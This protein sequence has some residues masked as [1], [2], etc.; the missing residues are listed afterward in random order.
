M[1]DLVIAFL[2]GTLIVA[3]GAF[4]YETKQSEDFAK[5]LKLLKAG[6]LATAYTRAMAAYRD[7][8]PRIA[9]WELT[10]LIALE[11]ED[12]KLGLE[13]NGA[14]AGLMLTHARLARLYH[15]QGR[16]VEAQTNADEAISFMRKLPG[17]DTAVTNLAGLLARLQELD[18]REK[19]TRSHEQGSTP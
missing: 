11:Q 14:L 9:I 13:T 15:Q 17:P 18:D 1:R 4:W 6:E 16:E 8:D 3:G 2:L 10:H 12:L 19:L 7:E 5:A